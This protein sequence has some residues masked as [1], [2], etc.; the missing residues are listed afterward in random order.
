MALKKILDKTQIDFKIKRL[1]LEIA[2]RNVFEASIIL[3]GIAAN[4]LLIANKLKQEIAPY[5]KGQ[6]SVLPLD[7]NKKTPHENNIAIS[8]D[9]TN[10]NVILVDDV[11]N[12]GRTLTYAVKPFLNALP[13]S[14][15]TLVLVE[16]THKLFPISADYVGQ[17]I[18]TTVQDYIEVQNENG[19]IISAIIQ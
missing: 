12:S 16:R 1:G 19:E 5:F 14:I 7:F 15:Q 18:N 3:V 17:S 9:V 8:Q 4:G 10:S 11:A 13:K 6:V 2:E